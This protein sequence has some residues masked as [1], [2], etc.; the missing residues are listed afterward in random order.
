MGKKRKAEVSAAGFDE[1]EEAESEIKRRR[2]NEIRKGI[3][4][5]NV[6]L[7][8]GRLCIEL[9]RIRQRTGKIH[10]LILIRGLRMRS[11]RIRTMRLPPSGTAIGIWVSRV[12][13]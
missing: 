4:G 12:L 7:L 9:T 3:N 2:E 13:Y 10:C 5:Y 1:E 11:P 6:S 8:A